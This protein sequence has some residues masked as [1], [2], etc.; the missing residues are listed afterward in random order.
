MLVCWF[1]WCFSCFGFFGVFLKR[2][3][4]FLSFPCRWVAEQDYRQV[5]W[6]PAYPLLGGSAFFIALGL[7]LQ[8][9]EYMGLGH[10]KK[11]TVPIV[12]LQT[13]LMSVCQVIIGRE[14]KP[15]PHDT[16]LVH[17]W[18]IYDRTQFPLFVWQRV[19]G[20]CDCLSA[21]S[22]ANASSWIWRTGNDLAK[23][24]RWQLTEFL[25]ITSFLSSPSAYFYSKP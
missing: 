18:Q 9:I 15:N 5:S 23:G 13:L 7:G 17:D 19:V 22:P 8:E 11:P 25:L 6:A 16:H 10:Q 24:F 20:P 14:E 12:Y 4:L 21:C 1:V 3:N 2:R